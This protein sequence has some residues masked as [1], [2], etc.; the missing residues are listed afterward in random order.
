MTDRAALKA[1]LHPALHELDVRIND[2]DLGDCHCNLVAEVILDAILPVLDEGVTIDW[3][4]RCAEPGQRHTHA[5]PMPCW[6]MSRESAERYVNYVNNR[7][8]GLH[9]LVY[10]RRFLG[11]WE[12]VADDA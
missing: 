1:A 9:E 3:G 11:E 6:F 4:V 7:A 5:G 12:A 10:R 2:L 8:L